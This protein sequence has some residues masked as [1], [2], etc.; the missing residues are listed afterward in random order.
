MRWSA[1]EEEGWLD[2]TLIRRLMIPRGQPILRPDLDLLAQYARLMIRNVA[3][4]S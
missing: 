4:I 1:E 3:S 2:A